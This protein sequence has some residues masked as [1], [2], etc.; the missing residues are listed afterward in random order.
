MLRP[1]PLKS[2]V[3]NYAWA[4]AEADDRVDFD[5]RDVFVENYYNIV[6]DSDFNN[7]SS[8]GEDDHRQTNC[9]VSSLYFCELRTCLEFTRFFLKCRN[10]F[11]EVCYA[12][13][14]FT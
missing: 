13:N 9:F 11:F 1:F 14:A 2:V 7:S 6:D 10:T 3:C 8:D 4:R 12:K 5:Y